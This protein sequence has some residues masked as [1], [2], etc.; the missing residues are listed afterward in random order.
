MT[1]RKLVARFNTNLQRV[2]RRYA[3]LW[4]SIQELKM[5]DDLATIPISKNMENAENPENSGLFVQGV[6]KGFWNTHMIPDVIMHF[7]RTPRKYG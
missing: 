1:G 4:V 6:F 2:A 3:I 7:L 5:T